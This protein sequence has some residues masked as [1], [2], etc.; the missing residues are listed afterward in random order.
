MFIHLPCY[1]IKINTNGNVGRIESGLSK[2]FDGVTALVLAHAIA[3]VDI[4]NSSYLKGIEVAV[5]A[6]ANSL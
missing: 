3:G 2:E 4:E 6:V 5:D 1:D